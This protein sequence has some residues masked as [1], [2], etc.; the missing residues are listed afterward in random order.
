[1]FRKGLDDLGL[2]RILFCLTV[3]ILLPFSHGTLPRMHDVE[4]SNDACFFL[5]LKDDSVR[6][7]NKLPQFLFEI[8]LL[9]G[10][11]T[12]SGKAL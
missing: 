3:T 6:F 7:E 8:L 9:P 4:H 1:M 5:N 2:L 12:T 11:G 10:N